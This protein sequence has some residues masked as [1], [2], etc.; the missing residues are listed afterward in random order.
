ME[1]QVTLRT[2]LRERRPIAFLAD[3]SMSPRRSEQTRA[4][5]ASALSLRVSAVLA[6]E[7]DTPRA[8][9][10]RGLGVRAGVPLVVGG[11]YH[12]K[13]TLLQAL[14]RGLC[15]GRRTLPEVLEA[16]DA[17]LET[18]GLEAMMEPGF[19]DRSRARRFETAAALNRLRSLRVARGKD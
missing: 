19:G 11:G 13:P 1:D 8:G 6:V 14:A 17:R 18:R 12:G 3:G 7:L 5:L 10:L 4:P 16:L 15:D 9:R 2:Q